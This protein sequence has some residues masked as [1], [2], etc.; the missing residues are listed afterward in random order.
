MKRLTLIFCSAAIIL[1]ACNNESKTPEETV[2]TD[3]PAAA[4]AEKKAEPYTMPDSATMMKNWAAYM[5]P[6][7]MHKMMASW[8]G[9]WT[10]EITMWETPDAPPQKSIGKAVNKMIMGGRYQSATYS[11]NMMGMPF[12]GQSTLAYDNNTKQ[13]ISS[14]ID[15]MGT[16]MMVLKGG[17]DPASKSMTLTGKMVDPISG[18]NRETEIR[19]VFKIIDDNTQTMEMYCPGM[20]GKEFKTMEIKY[21][22]NK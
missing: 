17:W 21:T 10:G 2:K 14:W 5:T 7:D 4:T 9:N 15:N 16:G 20:D 3:T 6:G 8:N 1:A 11:G 12:E 22:R 19:E 13:F 18:T